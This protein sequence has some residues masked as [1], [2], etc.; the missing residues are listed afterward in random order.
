MDD[1]V[2]ANARYLGVGGNRLIDRRP[3]TGM[4]V[5]VPEEEVRCKD[6]GRK[7]GLYRPAGE[8]GRRSWQATYLAAEEVS[9]MFAYEGY[10]RPLQIAIFILNIRLMTSWEEVSTILTTDTGKQDERCIDS[11]AADVVLLLEAAQSSWGGVASL[12]GGRPLRRVLFRRERWWLRGRKK[13]LWTEL[14]R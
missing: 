3:S 13:S 7:G 1:G 14:G 5:E 12:Y 11:R 4:K 2:G 9:Q 10:I 8:R 6:L